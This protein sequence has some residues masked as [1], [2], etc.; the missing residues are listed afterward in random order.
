MP[1]LKGSACPIKRVLVVS[2]PIVL[3]FLMRGEDPV[4]DTSAPNAVA[5]S[6]AAGIS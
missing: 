5:A 6:P 4:P 3:V 2:H 1:V